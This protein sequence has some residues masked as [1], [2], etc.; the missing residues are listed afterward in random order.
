MNLLI[1]NY[2]AQKLRVVPELPKDTLPIAKNAANV[3]KAACHIL[4]LINIQSK[5]MD[6]HLP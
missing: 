5:R 4:I 3:I 1:F 6:T 2:I